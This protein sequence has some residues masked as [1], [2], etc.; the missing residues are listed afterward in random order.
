MS[1][2]AT[3]ADAIV[4]VLV[5]AGGVFALI[6]SVGL[7]RLGDFFQ[8]QHGPSKAATLGIGC[9]VAGAVVHFSAARHG[10]SLH[11]LLVVVF[12]FMTTPASAH[13]LAKAALHRRLPGSPRGE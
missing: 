9:T 8:R 6:G 12:V 7:A 13:L 3:V 1:G 5:V 10:V 2:G 4:S 11:Q